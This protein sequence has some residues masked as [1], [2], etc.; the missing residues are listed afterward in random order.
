[1]FRSSYETWKTIETN[2]IKFNKADASI[3]TETH[4]P[5]YAIDSFKYVW[6]I[7]KINSDSWNLVGGNNMSNF[8]KKYHM[9]H[10]YMHTKRVAICV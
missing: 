8:L 4:I 9:F 10:K 2:L 3:T 6:K 7:E 1:M 5:S